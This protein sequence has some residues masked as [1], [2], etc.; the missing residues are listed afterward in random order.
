MAK[1]PRH[2]SGS[3]LRL[4]ERVPSDA[5]YQL[6]SDGEIRWQIVRCIR[7]PALQDHATW[8]ITEKDSGFNA[9]LY[10]PV[11]R[12]TWMWINVITVTEP[13]P[14]LTPSTPAGGNL[15]FLSC[16]KLIK[17]TPPNPR[18]LAKIRMRVI[19]SP[20]IAKASGKARNIK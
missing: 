14:A 13:R 1:E 6:K 2:H 18:K 7:N 5:R 8:P 9:G 19:L 12:V 15:S 16:A 17:S 11:G 4:I 10:F 20:S 3:R